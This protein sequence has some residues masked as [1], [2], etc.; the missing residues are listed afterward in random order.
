MTQ[1]VL[2]DA[3]ATKPK[4]FRPRRESL[5]RVSD[6]SGLSPSH[7]IRAKFRCTA[8]SSDSFPQ[9]FPFALLSAGVLDSR[10][11]LLEVGALYAIT[12][13]SPRRRGRDDCA[14]VNVI[15]LIQMRIPVF[16]NSVL[17]GAN[18]EKNSVDAPRRL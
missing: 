4:A 6:P 17:V 3:G 13:R 8:S 1:T 7:D 14:R 11:D 9:L 5:G 16:P 15:E 18:W 2:R 10:R 12:R